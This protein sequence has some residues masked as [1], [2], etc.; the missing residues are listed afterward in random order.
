MFWKRMTATAGWVGLVSGTAAAVV[1]AF[2]SEDAFGS[3]SIGVIPLS[4]Q[5]ASFVAASAAFVVD[6]VVSY[7]VSLATQPKPAAELR[8]FVYSLTPREQLRDPLAHMLPW[9]QRPAVLASIS[10]VM[11]IAL[12]IIF[13]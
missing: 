1:V 2:L 11:V 9:Y 10:L 5:G 4:G 6:I 8:G 13:W 12:N 7:V 3:A